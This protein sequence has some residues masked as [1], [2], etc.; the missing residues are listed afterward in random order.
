MVVVVVV[1][2][3]VRVVVV[4]VRVVVVICCSCDLALAT[5]AFGLMELSAGMCQCLIQFCCVI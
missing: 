4:V 3:M 5:L 1:V 2:M